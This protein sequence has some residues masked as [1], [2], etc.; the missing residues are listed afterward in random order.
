MK[1]FVTIA[2]D[3]PASSGKSTVSRCL[4]KDLNY[5]HIDTGAMYRS[6]TFAAI[7]NQIAFDDEKELF[8]LL[9][10]LDISF[11]QHEGKQHVYINQRDVTQNIR[12]REVTQH[13]SDVSAHSSIRKELVNRQRLLA[14]KNN[15]IMDGRD[16]GTV[17][18]PQAD[19]KFFLDASV[20]ERAHR[21]HKENL[22]RGLESSF[23]E[24]KKELEERD[25]KDKNREI[26]PLKPAED[27]IIIDTTKMDIHQVILEIKK[28]LSKQL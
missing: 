20:E 11:E 13:T 26:A 28:Y 5:I 22:E 9:T 16:I 2:I 3:G 6:L 1:K 15:V 25:F 4:A 14:E 8:N 7:E 19:F 10:K 24:I 12:T 17:V 27:S 18:L 23:E 21:R